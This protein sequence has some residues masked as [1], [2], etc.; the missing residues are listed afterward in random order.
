MSQSSD[1][2]ASCIVKP[3][4]DDWIQ[5][6]LTEKRFIPTVFMTLTFNEKRLG[7]VSPEKAYWW[8][9]RFVHAL[10]LD[11]FRSKNYRHLV[12]HSYFSYVCVHEYTVKGAVHLHCLTDNWIDFSLA[13]ELWERYCGY[14]WISKVPNKNL[15]GVQRLKALDFEYALRYV[16]KYILK[17]GT[18][19][20]VWIVQRRINVR[21]VRLPDFELGWSGYDLQKAMEEYDSKN[22]PFD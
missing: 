2:L 16:L 20:L 12:K 13:H 8:F 10:N 3:T 4:V 21:Q 19:P 7:D 17:G 11:V 1:D 9:R 18:H 5:F 6:L 15:R 14:A 22:P